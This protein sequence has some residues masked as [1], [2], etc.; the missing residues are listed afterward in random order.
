MRIA[1]LPSPVQAMMQQNLLAALGKAEDAFAA[2]TSA[3]DAQAAATMLPAAVPPAAQPATSV[4]MLVALAAAE[5]TAERRRK[6]AAAA[7]RGLSLLERLHAEL[8]AGVPAPE[9]LAELLE[10]SENFEMPDDPQLAT[11][12]RE[13]ELRVRVEIAKHD[14]RV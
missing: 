14:L 4:Q 2:A 7:D 3:A 9:R 1:A 6:M 8:V 5:P 10:W 13:I 11:V 12:A